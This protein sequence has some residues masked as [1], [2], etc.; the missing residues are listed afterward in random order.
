MKNQFKMK[1]RMNMAKQ[2]S[3]SPETKAVIRD[4]AKG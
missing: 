3:D 4:L 1:L 2:I